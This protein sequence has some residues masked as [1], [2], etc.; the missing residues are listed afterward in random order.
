V[1]SLRLRPA[2]GALLGM[3][4]AVPAFADDPAVTPEARALLDEV[5]AAY[6]ALPGYADQGQFPV[7][8]TIDGQ[9]VERAQNMPLAFER[10]NKLALEVD[11]V[12]LVCDGQ[13]LVTARGALHRFQKQ[14]APER[15]RLADVLVSPLGSMLVGGPL[16]SPGLVVLALL[17]EDDAAARVLDGASAARVEPDAA[18]AGIDGPLK[19]LVIERDR[20][21]AWRLRIDPQT[22]LVRQIEL[23]VD[24]AR[25]AEGA[26]GAPAPADFAARWT[27]GPI[28]AEPPSPDAFRF[29]PPKDFREVEVAKARAAAEVE[30]HPLLGQ[31]APEFQ[32]D[33]IEGDGPPKRLTKAD[34]A[35]QV[36][37]L[38]FWATWCGPC[39][40]ELPE[41]QALTERLARAHPDQV[42]VVAVSQDRAPEDG[43]PVRALVEK[44]LKDLGVTLTGGPVARVALDPEQA[45]G[46]AFGVE[47]LPTVVVLDAR[48]TVQ[49][50]HVGYREGVG[51][52][53][54]EE[55]EALLE[56]KALVEPKAGEAAEAAP[57]PGAAR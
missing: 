35:G 57:K 6:R 8:Y 50:V 16:E 38:D 31:A 5:A 14:P 4:V 22:K 30:A 48:G 12:R 56:G 17:L 42:L 25:L 27:S 3:L 2:L 24:A 32:L 23:V 13:T 39:R 55:I 49:A 33:V 21:P 45:V 19:T 9:A 47:G 40:A 53:L 11:D 29:E 54:G 37:V 41:I 10:P 46:E 43:G 26:A 28:A 51:E 1:Q 44:A 15:L 36:V 34:L 20:R 18:V 52:R 7:T